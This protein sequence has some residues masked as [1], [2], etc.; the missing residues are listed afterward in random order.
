[1]E[2]AP[3]PIFATLLRRYRQ[4]AGLRQEKLAERAGLSARTVGDL[5]RGASH[6]PRKDT[7]ELL[8]GALGLAA[9]ERATLAEAA[10]RLSTAS[11]SLPAS[12][13]PSSPAFVDRTAELTL[14]E[15]HLS[16]QGPPL[17]LL[18]GQ[19]GIGEAMTL[20][21]RPCPEG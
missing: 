10:Q 1:M 13:I 11:S 2:T 3:S 21:M 17:L 16:G 4:A 14:L 9:P 7:V 5:E 20:T 19:P 8:A 15:R 6:A 12:D 18:A